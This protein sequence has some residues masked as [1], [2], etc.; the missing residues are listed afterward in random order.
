[1]DHLSKVQ[2]T[3]KGDRYGF[4][5]KDDIGDPGK[6]AFVWRD[7]EQLYGIVSRLSMAWLL[8]TVVI[9]FCQ[10]QNGLPTI[11]FSHIA[12]T[13]N[14]LSYHHFFLPSVFHVSLVF[15]T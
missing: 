12:G 4:L 11:H 2:L 10:K 6:L 1:M 9:Y 14:G 7:R 13:N 15:F 3:Y 5:G 8:L